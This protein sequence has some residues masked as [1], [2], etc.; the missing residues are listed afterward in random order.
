MDGRSSGRFSSARGLHRPVLCA[1]GFLLCTA[2]YVQHY[3]LTNM[4]WW[5]GSQFCRARGTAPYMTICC[6]ASIKRPS[7]LTGVNS[8]QGVY[9]FA[10]EV[11]F[12]K[13]GEIPSVL[14]RSDYQTASGLL[15]LRAVC[16]AQWREIGQVCKGIR[17]QSE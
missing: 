2:R 11:G 3:G 12:I 5:W 9:E 13:G 1:S 16:L 4:R 15:I 6:R 14:T 7:G 8:P 17:V 10:S